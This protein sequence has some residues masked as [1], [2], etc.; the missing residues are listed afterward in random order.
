MTTVNL[1][2]AQ[3]LAL[4]KLTALVGVDQVDQIVAQ[5]P[6]V[7]TARLEAF[8]RF[9]ATLIGQVHDHVAAA[10]PTRYI[11]VPDE[12]TRPLVLSA[13]TFEGKRGE[14]SFS[15]SEK[16]KW[17]W[18]P[19]CSNLSKNELAWPSRSSVVELE[20][21]HLRAMSLLRLHSLHGKY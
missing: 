21:G 4:D 5:G 19:L 11:P 15:G 2:E 7:L 16:S 9:E 17:Q 20:N 18:L 1:S 13:K 3:R 6:G 8:M 12:R 10:M 14:I